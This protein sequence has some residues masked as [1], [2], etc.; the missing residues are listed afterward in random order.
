MSNKKYYL[1]IFLLFLLILFSLIIAKFNIKE[2]SL[3]IFG[4]KCIRPIPK[5]VIKENHPRIIHQSWKDKDIPVVFQKY[6]DSWT[7]YCFKD[8]KYMFWTDDDNFNLIK[9]HYPWFLKKYNELPRNIYRADVSRYFYLFHYGGIYTDLDNEC[10]KP[11]EHLL[12]NYSLVFGAM[13]GQYQGTSL[14]E[15]YVQNSFM[16]SKPRQE[17]WLEMILHILNSKG[18]DAPESLTGPIL[19]SNKIGEYRLRRNVS[20]ELI[21]Y[22]PHYFNP[23]SWLNRKDV[24]TSCKSHNQMTHLD[25]Q[26]C[27]ISMIAKGSFVVQYHA[28]T[29]G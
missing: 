5:I 21:V 23:F 22:P 3:N 20:D 7:K 18:N 11:F 27:R 28:H 25:W 8:W 10:L 16:Y 14:K 13:V 17:F 12:N 9:T 1:L 26:K 6:S 29:W 2:S 24:D 15:G 19:L 4:V